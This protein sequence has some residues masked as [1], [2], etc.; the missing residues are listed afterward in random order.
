MKKGFFG[1]M[2][3]LGGKTRSA[4]A[5]AIGMTKL[6]PV[7]KKTLAAQIKNRP[8]IALALLKTLSHR[9][10]D[11]TQAIGRLADQNKELRQKL[12][13]THETMKQLVEQ[14]KL[15]RQRLGIKIVGGGHII[16][17]FFIFK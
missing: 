5:V 3:L 11:D 8:E 2:A 1:E 6:L 13:E 15:L 9:I 16:S 4:T 10:W 17:Y 12:M 7:T 14:N